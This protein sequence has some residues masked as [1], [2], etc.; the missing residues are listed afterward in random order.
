MQKRFIGFTEVLKSKYSLMT[1][2]VFLVLSLMACSHI[3]FMQDYRDIENGFGEE[4]EFSYDAKY[5]ESKESN[6]TSKYK[7]IYCTPEDKRRNKKTVID[8][9]HI[10]CGL[11]KIQPDKDKILEITHVIFG[12][13]PEN[14]A[15][16]GHHLLNLKSGNKILQKMKIEKETDPFW[17]EVV[18][19]KIREGVYWKDLNSDG[20]VEF[21][22]LPKDT[23]KAVYRSAYIYTLKDNSFHFYGEGNYVWTTGEHVLLNCPNC[24]DYDLEAYKKCL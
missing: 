11:A 12:I 10:V 15:R 13:D 17:S 3:G 6:D 8:Y 21:A 14:N 9:L 4:Q 5:D 7:R 20:Y 16:I 1:F 19:V 23:G 18:F 24:W 22:I 2:A